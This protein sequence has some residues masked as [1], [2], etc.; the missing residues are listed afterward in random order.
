[1]SRHTHDGSNLGT[2][3]P[4]LN[5]M[6]CSSKPPVQQEGRCRSSTK[7]QKR[8]GVAA[9]EFAIVAPVFLLLVIGILELG[10]R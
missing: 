1:M 5:A 2:I 7:R 4:E 6:N 8:W 9:T 10:E 3:N